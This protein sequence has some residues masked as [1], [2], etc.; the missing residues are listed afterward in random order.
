[1]DNQVIPLGGNVDSPTHVV[2]TNF[3]LLKSSKSV[4]SFLKKKK[5]NEKSCIG[6]S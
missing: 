2:W 6:K 4:F 1:L 3:Y 5:S